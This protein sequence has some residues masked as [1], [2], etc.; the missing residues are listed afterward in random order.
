[1][2]ITHL[3]QLVVAGVLFACCA[4]PARSQLTVAAPVIDLGVIRGGQNLA[5]RFEL[6]NTGGAAIEILDVE[7]GCGCLATQLEQRLIP[8]GGRATLKLE[9]RTLG[10]ADG[11]HTW[12]LQVNY[13]SGRETKTLPLAVRGAVES[14]ISVQPAILGLHVAKTVR[15]LITLTDT[16]PTPL[17]VV[18]VEAR[19]PGVSVTHIERA[20]KLTKILVSADGSDLAAG[21]HEGLLSITTDDADY[22]QLRIPVVVTKAAAS[23]V[24]C[25]PEQVEL[26][27]A[28]GAATALVRLRSMDEEPVRIAK[29]VAGDA[30]LKCTWAPGPGNDATLKIQ[31]SA[32]PGSRAEKAVVE[33]HLA[34]P[35]VDV[36]TIPV[37]VRAED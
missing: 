33:V 34:A 30:A 3:L 28:A 26:R 4:V 25:S 36:L 18:D 14:E 22:R 5:H 1:M 11:A 9:L 13:R 8:A 32:L 23:A 24:R 29:I 17:R 12:R 19:A 10:L 35:R 37:F 27:P 20:G 2:R 7:R 15:Q 21:R 16:R 6:A 31:R